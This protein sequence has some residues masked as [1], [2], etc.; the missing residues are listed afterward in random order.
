MFFVEW[1][2]LDDVCVPQMQPPK[3]AIFELYSLIFLD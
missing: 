2:N 3:D 1:N